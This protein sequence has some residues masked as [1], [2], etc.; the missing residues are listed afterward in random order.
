MP[1]NKGKGGKGKKKGKKMGDEKRELKFKEVGEEY[2]KVV[3][4]LG[5]CRMEIECFDGKTRMG[6]VRGKFKNK[7][8]MNKDDIVLVGLRSFQDEKCD[9]IHKYSSVEIKKLQQFEEIPEQKEKVEFDEEK[10]ENDKDEDC[11]EYGEDPRYDEPPLENQEMN[12]NLHP[13][14]K[15][16]FANFKS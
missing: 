2:G 1:K 8:W 4:S 9:I 5:N 7:V 6:H 12:D 10:E 14:P 13:D 15:I 11:G 3:K 16:K